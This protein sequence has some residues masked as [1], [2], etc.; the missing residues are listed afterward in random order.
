MYLNNDTIATVATGPGGVIGI[1]RI[2]GKDA[3]KVASYFLKPDNFY[4]NKT[5][6]YY[7]LKIIDPKTKKFIDRSIVLTYHS[8]KSYSGEDMVEIFCH[9]SPYIVKKT[10][11]LAFE[12]GARQAREGEFSFRA[13]L[14][15]KIDIAQAE[16]INQL[17]K[18]ETE[19]QH[20]IALKQAEGSLS[21]KINSL[22]KDLIDLLSETELR[23]DDSYEEVE[24]IEQEKFMEKLQSIINSVDKLAQTYSSSHLIRDG[25]K[26]CLCGAPNCGK[27]TLLNTIIG[28]ERVITSPIPG[29]TRDVVEIITDINGFKTIFYDTAGIRQTDDP[30]EK[31]GIKKAIKTASS[32]DVILLLRDPNQTDDEYRMLKDKILSNISSHT[33]LIEATTKSDTVKKRKN[34][35]L[36]I[37][38]VTG[39]NIDRIISAIT[40]LKEKIAD[41][42]CDEI[43]VTERHYQCLIN[44]KNELEKIKSISFSNYEMI[45]EHLK[46][47]L[48]AIEEI[49]GKTLPEDIIKNIFSKF[50]VGK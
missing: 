45:S 39:E 32:S 42:F 19:K 35:L 15:G 28:Y 43:I 12:G 31:E 17:I 20:E 46:N 48:D 34:D 1:I 41:D 21:K 22:K 27:S 24:N 11:E 26:V 5:N 38:S 30:V 29:T 8:P 47:S 36:Y 10:L 44:A 49:A 40:D 13:Y 9:N 37:S 18:A 25:I 33:V 16:A 3:F 6:S 2:S 23:I 14:N 7:L 4:K 50:C